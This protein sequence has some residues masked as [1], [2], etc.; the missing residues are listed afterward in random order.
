[1]ENYRLNPNIPCVCMSMC[2]KMCICKSGRVVFYILTQWTSIG[3]NKRTVKYTEL[4][5]E[6]TIT[7]SLSDSRSR[8]QLFDELTVCMYIYIY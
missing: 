1:M 7:Y 4:C 3:A 6:Y 5:T 2:E 8:K